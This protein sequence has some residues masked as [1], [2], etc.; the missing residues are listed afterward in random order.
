MRLLLSSLIRWAL[1]PCDDTQPPGNGSSVE[2]KPFPLNYYPGDSRKLRC[3]WPPQRSVLLSGLL[4]QA[5]RARSHLSPGYRAGTE[6]RFLEPVGWPQQAPRRRPGAKRVMCLCCSLPA[7][8]LSISCYLNAFGNLSVVTL[9]SRN[10]SSELTSAAFLIWRFLCR[11]CFVFLIKAVTF[12]GCGGG[13]VPSVGGWPGF[14]GK[15]RIFLFILFLGTK[16]ADFLS[17]PIQTFLWVCLKAI[18]NL[19]TR[20]AFLSNRSVQWAEGV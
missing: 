10:T 1:R 2:N 13:H 11:T 7:F 14:P 20:T 9:P 19:L 3:H 5:L 4:L 6:S 12:R 8:Q 17:F 18:A 15:A 16:L